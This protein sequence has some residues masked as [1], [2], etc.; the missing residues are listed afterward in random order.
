MLTKLQLKRLWII[1]TLCLKCIRAAHYFVPVS[2][3]NDRLW[4]FTQNCYGEVCVVQWCKLFGNSSEKTHYSQ[5]FKG[6]GGHPM[7]K[8]QA[9]NRICKAAEMDEQQYSDFGKDVKRARDKYFA[10]SDFTEDDP[11]IFPNPERLKETCLELRRILYEIVTAQESADP[12]YQKDIQRD[13]ERVTND[14]FLR[15]VLEDA[16]KLKSLVSGRQ[17]D[18]R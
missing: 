10:H 7:C 4:S 9:T 8:A 18:Q 16:Q 15:L 14:A 2:C 13:M 17:K 6:L 3:S 5:L 1:N 11:I 12:K